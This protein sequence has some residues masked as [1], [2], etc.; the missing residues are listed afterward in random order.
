MPHRELQVREESPSSPTPPVFTLMFCRTLGSAFK[1][2]TFFLIFSTPCVHQLNSGS[3]SAFMRTSYCRTPS[4]SRTQSF[5]AWQSWVEFYYSSFRA[6]MFRVSDVYTSW[7]DFHTSR[8]LKRILQASIITKVRSLKLHFFCAEVDHMGVVLHEN[9]E[10][11]D[12]V[13]VLVEECWYLQPWKP[14]W[15]TV[16]TNCV[17]MTGMVVV[18]PAEHAVRLR[19]WQFYMFGT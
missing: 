4:K 10:N 19:V 8:A 2:R 15:T 14:Q 13:I 9:L 7:F 16:N 6:G 5:L 11:L 18:A 3:F 12:E 1:M 17:C